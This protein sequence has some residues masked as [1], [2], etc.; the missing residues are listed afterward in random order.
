MSGLENLYRVQKKDITKAG[1]VLAGAFQHDP[2]W[3]KV[4]GEIKVDL[5]RIFFSGAGEVL[6]PIRPRVCHL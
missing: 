2:V 4:V 1:A 3:E 5:Q 6:P